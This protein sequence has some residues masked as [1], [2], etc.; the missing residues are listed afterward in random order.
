MPSFSQTVRPFAIPVPRFGAR[1]FASSFPRPGTSASWTPSR[2][3]G[4]FLRL[5][6]SPAYLYTD[7]GRTTR[8]TAGQTCYWQDDALNRTSNLYQTDATRRPTYQTSP[9]RLVFDG[10]NDCFTNDDLTGSFIAP[11]NN[12]IFTYHCL[13]FT[14][15]GYYNIFEKLGSATPM[16][17]VD[18][19]GRF[20][21][22]TNVVSTA[23]NDDAWHTVFTWHSA[24]GSQ[25]W[26]DN[27]SVG[28]D[29][30]AVT[31]SG[32]AM[33]DFVRYGTT[34]PYNGASSERGFG[35]LLP[36]SVIRAQL[37]NYLTA[38]VA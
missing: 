17:W 18:G 27:V 35:E 30:T 19:S 11:A 14:A 28:T 36:S 33:G 34:S 4:L 10:T 29:G 25:L 31:T 5:I 12:G 8:P 38:G 15:T 20:E 37:H 2:I 21:M 26:V 13:K 3:P 32:A 9:N 7:S 1:R 23:K 16:L 24:S 22:N 6:P